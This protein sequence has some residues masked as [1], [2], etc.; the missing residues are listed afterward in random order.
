MTTGRYEK[1]S[2]RTLGRPRPSGSGG[3]LTVFWCIACLFVI[4]HVTAVVGSTP[5]LIAMFESPENAA[6]M[7]AVL[8]LKVWLWAPFLILAPLGHRLMPAVTIVTVLIATIGESCV[9]YLALDLEPFKSAMVIGFNVL[10]AAIFCSYL[11]VSRRAR[12]IRLSARP[13]DERARRHFIL[14]LLVLGSLSVIIFAG[15]LDAITDRVSFLSAY[16]FA[17]FLAVV[18]LI[19]PVRTLQTGRTAVNNYLR[20]DIGIWTAIV[21]LLHFYAGTKQSMT[22]DYIAA[23]VESAYD[24]YDVMLREQLFFW[25]T[26]VGFVTLLILLLP[27]A[28]SNDRSLR[29]L[30]KQWWKSLHRSSY[31]LFALM[32]VHAVVFQYLEH[33]NVLF[34]GFLLI[35][36]LVVLGAQIAGF[37]AVMRKRRRH[38]RVR[39]RRAAGR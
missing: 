33:R 3:W 34:V 12:I 22:Q 7:R 5:G 2:T 23:Y 8:W 14:L 16:Q 38:R 35:V 30:G 15:D 19:G 27:L 32:V 26:I 4:W 39:A 1:V 6:I 10:I 18:L 36:T 25:G 29:R 9:I 28:L 24:V 11:L 37:V 21:G 17:I 13:V 20:R 31:I